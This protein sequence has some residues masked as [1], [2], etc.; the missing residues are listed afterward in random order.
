VLLQLAVLQLAVLE[1]VALLE[2][3]FALMGITH[4]L[5]AFTKNVHLVTQL[6]KY[7]NA[8]V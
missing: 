7:N 6:K 8:W 4:Q 2:V 3:D 5:M 1:V